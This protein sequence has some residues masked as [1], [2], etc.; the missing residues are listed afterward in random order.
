MRKPTS[1]DVASY[2]AVALMGAALAACS[3]NTPDLLA[4]ATIGNPDAS[5]I[6]ADA[7]QA[8]DSPHS[9]DAMQ[10]TDATQTADALASTHVDGAVLL[11][12][13]TAVGSPDAHVNQADAQDVQVDA[14]VNQADAHDVQIDARI[15]AADA[16]LATADAAVHSADARIVVAPDAAPPDAPPPDASPPDASIPDATP[17][18]DA[19]P[20]ATP[21]S[22]AIET[23]DLS[24]SACV[25]PNWI[26][27]DDA[28]LWVTCNQGGLGVVDVA[29]RTVVDAVNVNGQAFP[30][31]AEVWVTYGNGRVV[32]VVDPSDDTVTNS[33]TLAPDNLDQLGV[34]DGT[35]AWIGNQG[36]DT[37]DKIDAA[38]HTVVDSIAM[39]STSNNGSPYSTTF[40]GTF[41]WVAMYRDQSIKKIDPLT[42]EVVGT[43]PIGSAVL[44][45][46]VDDKNA[47][48]LATATGVQKFD[49][50]T[51]TVVAT[52]DGVYST[53]IVAAA[54]FI[55]ST[56]ISQSRVVKIDPNS[57]S[58]VTNIGVGSFPMGLAYDGSLLWVTNQVSE[59]LTVIRP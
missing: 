14:R 40:D 24:T 34:F 55:W 51:N 17:P 32:S 54:G 41:I 23:I 33:I 3:L 37:V 5:A 15:L 44:Y 39:N 57:N 35:F 53:A 2:F 27:Y 31:N 42:D 21:Q 59:T 10:A 25:G 20:D 1:N 4:D 13:A 52:V 58:I 7:P 8:S 48:W 50:T 18:A 47:L 56:D 49:P 43:F 16:H 36:G 6:V 9:S 26:T 28:K 12:D 19:R 38:S 11:A 29:T 46:A 30:V 22:A 45:I